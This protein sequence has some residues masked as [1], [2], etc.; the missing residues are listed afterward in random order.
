MAAAP[1][2]QP[3]AGAQPPQSGGVPPQGG[4]PAPGGGAGAQGT[5]NLRQTIEEFRQVAM[6]VQMLSTKYPESS[7]IM[8][9]ILPL[10]QKAMT[11]VAG[12]PARQ[13]DP[14][15]PPVGA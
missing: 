8:Q 12:N 15:A 2:P 10:L 11:T 1:L 9:Q 6:Q 13:Q 4:Q 3:P 14:Q 5:G 7:D